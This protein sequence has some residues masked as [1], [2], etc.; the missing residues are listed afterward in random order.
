MRKSLISL[1]IAAVWLA[2]LGTVPA[3]AD[4]HPGHSPSA[5]PDQGHGAGH[6]AAAPTGAPSGDPTPGASANPTPPQSGQQPQDGRRPAMNNARNKPV[7]LVARLSGA[8]EVPASAGDADG[9]GTALVR[10]QGDRVTFAL[11]WTGITAPT[12]GHIHRGPAGVNGDVAVPLFSS[13]MPATVT[14]AAGSVTVPDPTI[15]DGLR[16]NPG[17]WYVNL[18][19]KENP[20]G[21]VRAQLAPLGGRRDVLRLL[22]TGGRRAFLSGDQEVPV[23]GGPAVGDPDGRAVAFVRPAGTGSLRF[24]MAWIGVAPTLAHIH[25]GV[26]GTNG[27]VTANLVTTPVP[28]TVFAVAGTATGVEPSVVQGIRTNPRNWYAN[29]HSAE[30]PGGAVRGQLNR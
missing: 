22:K 17:N 24:S 12:L 20:K 29:I 26:F 19:T 3:H 14:S 25:R 6:G 27:P 8:N 18:H 2:L 9:S 28:S 30:F 21:A 11:D 16:A 15:A 10:V 5:A 1:P 23:K 4:G 13:A 7:F